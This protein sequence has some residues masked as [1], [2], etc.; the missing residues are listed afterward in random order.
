MK[1]ILI[2]L[3]LIVLYFNASAQ[4]TVK[5]D[6]ALLL[7]YY[8]NQRYADAADY[9]KKSYPE[10]IAD[11]KILARLAYVS[12]MAGKLPEAE[13]YY[14]RVYSADTTNTAI[15]FNLGNINARRGNNLKALTWYKKILLRDST[16]FNVYKQMASLSQNTGNML[17]AIKYLLKANKL[18]PIEPDVAFDLTNIYINLKLYAKGDTVVTAALQADTAN[19]LLLFGK[20]QIDYRLE[21]YPET[22]VVCNKLIQ[23]GNQTSAVVNMLGTSYFNLKNYNQCIATFKLMEDNQ[24]ASETSYYYTAMS[25]KALGKQSPAINYFEKAIKEAISGNVDSY[26]SE[27]GDSYDKLHQLKNSANAYQKSLLYNITPITYYV[28]ANLYDSE[29]KNKTQALKYYKKYL[30]CDPPEKQKSF[31]DYS[32][33]RVKRLAR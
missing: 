14:Q 24:T 27:M 2:F 23:E 28:L 18:N 21:K 30:A 26:Y 6:D 19:L 1:S 13:D 11:T 17:D 31:V 25:F 12:Q 22:V 8:Q 15:L 33:D 16:N 32:K 29:I 4:Q 3:L 10:P 7:E 5:A 20:A 9:L